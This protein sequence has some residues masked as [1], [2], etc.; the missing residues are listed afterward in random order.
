[1]G[2]ADPS[3]PFQYN[4]NHDCTEGRAESYSQQQL[5]L[6]RGMPTCLLLNSYADI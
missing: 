2:D 3:W 5:G 6:H 1:M 4:N